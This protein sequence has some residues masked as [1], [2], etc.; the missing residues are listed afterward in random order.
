VRDFADIADVRQFTNGISRPRPDQKLP[1]KEFIAALDN[2]CS[3]NGR[4]AP[5]SQPEPIPIVVIK[6]DSEYELRDALDCRP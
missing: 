1:G 6:N 4:G 3:E 5:A 2:S